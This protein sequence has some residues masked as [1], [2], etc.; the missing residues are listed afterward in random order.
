[1]EDSVNKHKDQQAKAMSYKEPVHDIPG[2]YTTAPKAVPG[3][4]AG[5][6]KF[7]SASKNTS[8]SIVGY[9]SILTG[10]SCLFIATI[11]LSSL[12]TF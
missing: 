5:I 2:D 11:R 3:L 9:L 4:P 8:E 7:I 6:E 1:M 10:I 12:S